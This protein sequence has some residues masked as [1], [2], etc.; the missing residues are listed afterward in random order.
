MRTINICNLKGGVAKT[1]TSINM[2]CNLADMGRRVLLI[3]NDKQ[4]NASQLFDRHS[5][6]APSLAEV[7][8]G[9]ASAEEAI[10][11]TDYHNL[12]ILPANMNLLTAD[13]EILMDEDVPQHEHLRM[14]LSGIGDKY[15]FCIIDNAPDVSMSVINALTAGDDY[16][17]PV[18][19]D[20]FTFEGVGIM[21]DTANQV[22]DN[23][24]PKLN[25]CGCIITSYRFNDVNRTGATY[26]ENSQY[27][28]FRTKIH[29]TPKVDESTFAGQPLKEYSPRS[30][31]ARNYQQM[32]AE[33]L[34]M[35]RE[36]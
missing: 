21:V 14:A 26:L 8:T 22:R 18:K 12:D 28:M 24:N 35:I 10:C 20:C 19:A 2:A 1:T 3:D 29:W 27:K 17:I 11:Q 33:Y 34:D 23:Y 6:E 9:K 25:F 7:L 31:A 5:Y 4:A 32:T 16:I 30:W 15:D 36:A 13:K